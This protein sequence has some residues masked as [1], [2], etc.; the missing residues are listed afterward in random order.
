MNHH[1]ESEHAHNN[2]FTQSAGQT[3]ASTNPLPLNTGQK[4]AGQARLFHQITKI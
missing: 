2:L 1:S 3:D 4:K